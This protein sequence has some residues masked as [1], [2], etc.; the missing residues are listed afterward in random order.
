MIPSQSHPL[1]PTPRSYDA[2]AGIYDLLAR[3]WTGG[4][5]AAA[6][7]AI[8]ERVQP[9]HR[10]LM[11]GVGGGR[12]AAA[13]ARAGG[14]LTLVDL[15]PAMLRRA[16]ARVRRV[17]GQTPTALCADAL[18]LPPETFDVVCAH[19]FLNVFAPEEVGP[20]I[21]A[22]ARHVRP[23]GVLSIADFAPGARGLLQQVHYG[24]PMRL[25]AALGL[26]ARHPI[27]DYAVW[28]PDGW[29][30]EATRGARVF[31]VGPRWHRSWL[32]RAPVRQV[33]STTLATAGNSS[34]PSTTT[35]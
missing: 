10:V 29:Q 34:H 1:V 4:A 2:V 30:L 21:E 24:L 13:I 23:G 3:L 27:Y 7:A 12:D 18:A 20:A 19:Y 16:V 17:T 25:F 15:S 31:R 6:G 22:L 26:C 9:G 35:P 8:A 5:I 33:G 11:A 28:L 32:L 14:D